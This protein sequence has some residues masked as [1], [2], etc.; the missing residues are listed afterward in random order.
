M[1]DQ[2]LSTPI[3]TSI[4]VL[5]GGVEPPCP[6]GAPDFESGASANSATPA[7]V[8]LGGNSMAHCNKVPELEQC[9][10]GF[11]Q[12]QEHGKATRE[13]VEIFSGTAD[14][15]RPA[16]LSSC[17]VLDRGGSSGVKGELKYCSRRLLAGSKLRRCRTYDFARSKRLLKSWCMS[18]LA[19]PPAALGTG[20]RDSASAPNQH[21]HFEP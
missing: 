5:E 21:A 14:Q 13:A 4:L 1:P 8:L 6:R 11:P 9:Q 10:V 15:P 18:P 19:N 7:G 3:Q 16:L 2:Q 12:A 17:L 20:V